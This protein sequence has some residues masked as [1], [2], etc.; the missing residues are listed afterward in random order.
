MQN[1]KSDAK[2]IKLVLRAL[3]LTSNVEVWFIANSHWT[4]AHFGKLKVL[5]K[6]I[7]SVSYGNGL[8][9]TCLSSP[10]LPPPNNSC[11]VW[12]KSSLSTTLWENYVAFFEA[13]SDRIKRAV[14]LFDWESALTDLDVNER[15]PI[16]NDTITNIMSNFVPNEIIICDD[17][18]PLWMKTSVVKWLI[19]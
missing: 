1:L 14:D 10:P 3:N 17:H 8:W 7:I 5:N 16:F 9:S 2:E 19:L 11:K 15:V 4:Y 6:F 18:E 13:N 12:V